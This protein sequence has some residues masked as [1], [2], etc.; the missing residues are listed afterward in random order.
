MDRVDRLLEATGVPCYFGS[1]RWPHPHSLM[2]G[3]QA[4]YAGGEI[5]IDGEEIVEA[6]WFRADEMPGLFRGDFSIA[7]WMIRD[8][9]RRHGG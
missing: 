3:Y 7:Q 9:L 5:A 8:F 6:G 1:Q 4:T 2:L